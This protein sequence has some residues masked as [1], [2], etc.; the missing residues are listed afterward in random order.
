MRAVVLEIAQLVETVQD[1][2]LAARW[3][4][5]ADADWRLL[6]A[7]RPGRPVGVARRH[8]KWVRARLCGAGAHPH[9]LGEAWYKNIERRFPDVEALFVPVRSERALVAVLVLIHC[10]LPNELAALVVRL[11]LW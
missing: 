8:P 11:A 5:N 4:S 7:P 1:A 6:P 2:A 10:G 3:Y 9:D